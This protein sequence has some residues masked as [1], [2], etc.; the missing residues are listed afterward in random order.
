MGDEIPD[1]RANA[2]SEM[3]ERVDTPSAFPA[4]R[5]DW[6]KAPETDPSGPG[7]H[8]STTPTAPQP[9]PPTF[10]RFELEALEYHRAHTD[11]AHKRQSSE[12]CATIT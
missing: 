7:T 1:E 3:S 8:P 5:A 10:T 6:P 9:P 12:K 11:A 4:R 2:M